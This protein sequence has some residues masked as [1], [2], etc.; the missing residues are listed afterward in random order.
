MSSS[1]RHAQR[2]A[3][4][5]KFFIHTTYIKVWI[6]RKLMQTKMTFIWKYR[7]EFLH[8]LLTNRMLRVLS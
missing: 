1:L 4:F 7:V 3:I 8:Q 6:V 5:E 2:G